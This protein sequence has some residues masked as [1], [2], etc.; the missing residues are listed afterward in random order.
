M[1][2]DSYGALALT[3]HSI[4]KSPTSPGGAASMKEDTRSVLDMLNL[5]KFVTLKGVRGLFGGN[6]AGG[7][8]YGVE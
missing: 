3:Q 8:V 1:T 7:E 4:R 5:C 6:D 2:L